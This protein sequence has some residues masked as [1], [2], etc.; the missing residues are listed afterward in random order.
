MRANTAPSH[1]RPRSAR[2]STPCRWRLFRRQA[3]E[4][5]GL[6]AAGRDPRTHAGHHQARG[7]RLSHGARR[8]RRGRDDHRRFARAR[9]H[10]SARKTFWGERI[11]SSEAGESVSAPLTG[12]I[13]K[14]MASFMGQGRTHLRGAGSRHRPH[15]RG[16]QRAAQGQLAASPEEA[17]TLALGRHQERDPRCLL[18]RHR[19]LERQGV[20]ARGS[21]R[22]IRRWV[23][24]PERT[25][26]L[27]RE[28]CGISCH[29]GPP[30][31]GAAVSPC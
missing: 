20:G 19:K 3:R 15:A 31:C 12:T 2:A 6:D 26:R 11:K 8:L 5:V 1:C 10:T 7:D 25:V 21:K 29:L 18:S 4:L 22:S 24:L 28:L 23:R 16:V 27:F 30:V 14:A 9:P 17:R 13:D